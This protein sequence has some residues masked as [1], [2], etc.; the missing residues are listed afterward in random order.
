M[1]SRIIQPVDIILAG[2]LEYCLLLPSRGWKFSSSPGPTETGERV[3]F[4]FML[5]GVGWVLLRRFSMRP[6]FS[7][8]LG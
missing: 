7:W 5:A 3:V 4:P 6:L 8:S 1:R 2:E